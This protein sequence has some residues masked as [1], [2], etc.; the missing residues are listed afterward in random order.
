M[1]ANAFQFYV[2]FLKRQQTKVNEIEMIK[3]SG[4]QGDSFA[5]RTSFCDF[6]TLA[7]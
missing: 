4:N 7:H 3:G 1:I 5:G 2:Y 6:I